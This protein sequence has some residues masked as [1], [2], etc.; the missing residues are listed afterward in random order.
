MNYVRQW[1][2]TGREV[3]RRWEMTPRSMMLICLFFLGGSFH[4]FFQIEDL[5]R[6]LRGPHAPDGMV[7]LQLA[8]TVDKANTILSDWARYDVDA[9][10]SPAP[11]P[12]NTDFETAFEQGFRFGD[13]FWHARKLLRNDYCFIFMYGAGLYLILTFLARTFDLV[14][15]PRSDGFPE[16]AGSAPGSGSMGRLRC[17]AL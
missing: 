12:E 14:N 5:N 7:S 9:W 1:I 6:P 13:H 16:K 15:L 17:H 8:G 10:D 3:F 2:S 4:Y 11:D